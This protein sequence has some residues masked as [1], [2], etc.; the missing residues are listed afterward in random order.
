MYQ[1][2]VPT[3]ATTHCNNKTAIMKSAIVSANGSRAVMCSA[4]G[5]GKSHGTTVILTPQQA[6]LVRGQVLFDTVAEVA[7]DGGTS[8]APPL[9]P[10]QVFVCP[11]E[12]LFYSQCIEKMVLNSPSCP[13]TIVEFGAGDGSPVIS[14]L[15]KSPPVIDRV[16][17][18]YEISPRAAQMAASSAFRVG[19]GEA[20]C[21][22]NSCF[23]EGLK[24]TPADCLISNPPYLPAPDDNIMMPAL[25]GGLDGAE[26]TRDLLS[27]GFDSTL[28]MIS[29]YSNPVLTL[30]HA[31][32]QGYAITDFL[33]TPL[34]FGTY[35]SEPKVK[36]WIEGMRERG[37]AFYT[38]RMYFLAGVLFE[39]ADKA[40]AEAKSDLFDELLKVLTAF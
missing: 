33:V 6:D 40:Q 39:K 14:A 25:W 8:L 7:K 18:A 23:W 3:S 38:H 32:Q 27:A 16:I 13:R 20:Y 5:N 24:Q 36:A 26:L 11:E 17:H 1:R 29:A 22:H 12:S 19:L 2:R 37:E 30:Q 31:K 15:L 4:G 9:T 21:V 34:P 35:S 28:L 10:G